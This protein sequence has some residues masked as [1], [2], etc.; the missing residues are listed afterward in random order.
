MLTFITKLVSDSLV[1]G[2]SIFLIELT[3]VDPENSCD[4][5]HEKIRPCIRETM[6]G[7]ETCTHVTVHTQDMNTCQAIFYNEQ[8]TK[9]HFNQ[10]TGQCK[11][12]GGWAC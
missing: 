5:Q 3:D 8:C 10:K 6:E 4:E 9:Y 11:D 7:C 2:C 1:A 12:P